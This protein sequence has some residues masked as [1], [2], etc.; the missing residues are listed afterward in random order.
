MAPF[1]FIDCNN[2]DIASIASKLIAI[3]KC[4]GLDDGSSEA[5]W[6]MTIPSPLMIHS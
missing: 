2:L 4:Y 5:M 1:V 6:P 3:F